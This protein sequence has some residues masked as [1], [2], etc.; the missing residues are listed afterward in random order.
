MTDGVYFKYERWHF[1]VK[2]TFIFI[3][4]YFSHLSS[5]CFRSFSPLFYPSWRI[6]SDILKLAIHAGQFLKLLFL[7][8]T[9]SGKKI[10]SALYF[11]YYS[12]LVTS[13]NVP[14][15]VIRNWG[16]TR[17]QRNPNCFSLHTWVYLSWYRFPLWAFS[18]LFGRKLQ[19][20]FFTS[21]EQLI[22]I[23]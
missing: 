18:L 7:I 16:E 23:K 1:Y 2:N 17:V 6:E 3:S 21:L 11:L 12:T 8:L 13:W 5:H 20:H 4:S 10:S 14:Q 22:L 9:Q 19:F 15:S